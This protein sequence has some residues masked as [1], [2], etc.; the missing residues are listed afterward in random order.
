MKLAIA[1]LLVAAILGYFAGK[2]QVGET[3]EPMVVQAPELPNKKV[4]ELPTL[5]QWRE[6]NSGDL[7]DLAPA[8]TWPAIE[9]LTLDELIAKVQ[10]MAS[11]TSTDYRDRQFFRMLITRWRDIDLYGLADYANEIKNPYLRKET[12]TLTLTALGEQ[13]YRRGL[14][15]AALTDDIGKSE[16]D[17]ISGLARVDPVRA[18]A[19]SSKLVAGAKL[20]G[21]ESDVSRLPVRGIAKKWAEQDPEAAMAWASA[22]ENPKLRA[23]AMSG[24]FGPMIEDDP[25]G[26]AAIL[27]DAED[28]SMLE[29]LAGTLMTRW[30]K[31]DRDA[32]IAWAAGLPAGGGKAGAFAQL[33]S[34]EPAEAVALM[35]QDNAL[36]LAVVRALGKRSPEATLSLLESVPP[37][38]ITRA[39]IKEFDW[40][41]VQVSFDRVLDLAAKITNRETREALATRTVLSRAWRDPLGAAESAASFP[42]PELSESLVKSVVREWA[43]REY[44]D[45]L[46][47]VLAR[48]SGAGSAL[49]SQ[50]VTTVASTR[51]HP[52]SATLV[53]HFASTPGA[54]NDPAFARAAGNVAGALAERDAQN[55]ADWVDSLPGGSNR[56]NALRR[57]SQTWKR[58]EPARQEAWFAGLTQEDRAVIAR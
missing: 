17:L 42:H 6:M 18:A 4:P 24:A 41:A 26:V 29:G 3:T 57:L 10:E 7:S 46:E 56:D 21:I 35:A 1:I 43:L 44:T 53:A 5:V 51:P 13:D 19:E 11:G 25:A 23:S 31:T 45:A 12:V 34:Q 2:K 33:A 14:T 30:A 15:L 54:V 38:M 28:S 40:R 52:V 37:E 48:P 32:A 36:T 39:D 8:H 20:R 49:F 27:A 47:W 22:L 55:A 16:C 58:V 9:A 50:F